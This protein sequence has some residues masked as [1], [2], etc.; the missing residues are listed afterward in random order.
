[1]TSFGIKREKKALTYSSQAV[2]AAEIVQAK[3][4]N[5]INALAGKVAGLDVI[6]TNAGVGSATRVLLRGNRSI[7]GNNQPLYVIDGVPIDNTSF[8]PFSEGGGIAWGDGIGNINPEDIESLNVLKGPSATALYGSRANN[9]AI[10]ITTK[11]GTLTKGIGVEY[12]LNYSVET[13]VILSRFQNVYG[14]GSGGVYSE[15][16]GY[17]WGPLLDGREVDHWTQDKNSPEYNTTYPFVAHPNNLE[18]FLQTGANLTNSLAISTGNQNLQG[19]FSFT[20][21]QS[22]GITPGNDL[23]RNNFD[24]RMSGNL[25]KN[26]SFDLKLTY[27]HQLVKNRIPMGDDFSNPLRSIILLPNNISIDDAR[28][29]EYYNDEGLLVQNFPQSLGYNPFWIINRMPIEDYRN[30]VL[31]MSSLKYEILAGL[32]VQ[33]RT[34]LDFIYDNST[35]KHYTGSYGQDDQGVYYTDHGNNYEMNNDLLLNYTGNISSGFTINVS[36]GGNML[37]KKGY[38]LVDNNGGLLKPNLFTVSN[39]QNLTGNES[40]YEKKVNSVFGSATLGYRKYLFLDLTARNDW[41]STLP[42]ESWSYFY[43]SAGLTWIISD[44]VKSRPHWITFAKARVSFAQVGNDT[45][46]YQLDPVFYFGQGGALGFATRGT[47]KPPTTLKPEITTSKELGFEI[48]F[49]KNR[50][51]L[52]LTW[53]K[54]NSK[55]QLMKVPLPTPSGYSDTFINAGNIQ[56][57]GVEA[58]LNLRPLDSELSWDI[59]LNLAA[60]KSLVVELSE[61]LSEYTIRGREMMTTVKVVEGQKYGDIFTRGFLRNDSGRVLIDE[62]GLPM[63]T[64]GQTLPMGNYNPDWIGGVKNSFF[65]KGFDLSVLIDIRMG[66]DVFSYTEAN[67]AG[68]GFSDYTLEGRDEL[69]VNGVIQILDENGNVTGEKENDIKT[70]AEAYWMSLGGRTTPVGEPFKYDA[71]NIRLRE[72]VLGYTKTFKGGI[73][74][75]VRASLY[76]RNLFFIM[77]KA[78]ILDPNLMVGNTN[79]QGTESYGLPGTRTIGMNLRVT[80]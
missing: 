7:S 32:S 2:P 5:A 58:T 14:Q 30:R 57:S 27:F 78:K 35:L 68:Y 54:S 31:E 34:S 24:L 37:T 45:D 80:F 69:L 53:Y 13:P 38:Y 22:S 43:P 40:M 16:V 28:D 64:N 65:W 26:L 25:V 71:S 12:S 11:K 63:L 52:D 47:T 62:N 66:G 51:G 77:N 1:V 9:G 70:T 50:I 6:K 67:I 59:A 39:A 8:T 56:N 15:N 74:R 41:S 61:G 44:M 76:G 73:V 49:L 4:L 20:N 42:Q 48:R 46:P 17:E 60:N 21:T 19:Y 23:K 33:L 55:N 3:D 36:A 72:A 75:S 29:F 10:I 79:A 18:D